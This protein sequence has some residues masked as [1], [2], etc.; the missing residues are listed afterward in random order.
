MSVGEPASNWNVQF[1][2][3]SSR[4]LITC[5]NMRVSICQPILAIRL[6]AVVVVEEETSRP[7]TVCVLQ[8]AT[9]FDSNETFLFG[10]E[11]FCFISVEFQW[12][13]LVLSSLRLQN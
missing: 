5:V 3:G 1:V 7:L 6:A 12:R 11:V 13:W 9:N 4:D 10:T 2:A 8:G